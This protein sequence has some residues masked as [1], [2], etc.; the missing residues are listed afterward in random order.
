MRRC[1]S[2]HNFDCVLVDGRYV[3]TDNAGQHWANKTYECFACGH[4]QIVTAPIARLP[5]GVTER[6]VEQ[7]P[8]RRKI[9]QAVR[10]KIRQAVRPIS[11]TLDPLRILAQ[12]RSRRRLESALSEPVDE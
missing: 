3:F 11:Y 10:R 12:E 6:R 9:R 5:K 4:E 7:P 1:E 2:C 8:R